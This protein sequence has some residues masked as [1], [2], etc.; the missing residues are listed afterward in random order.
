[1]TDKPK[2]VGRPKIYA[3]PEAAAAAAKI[4]QAAAM[5][6]FNEAKRAQKIKLL[7]S[8]DRK[9]ESFLISAT[10]KKAVEKLLQTMRKKIGE[11]YESH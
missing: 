3:T 7:K 4:S 9:H 2:K 11:N 8:E 5:K 10:E 1:M 6:R